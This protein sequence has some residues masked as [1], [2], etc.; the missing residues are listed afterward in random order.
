[1]TQFR[2]LVLDNSYMLAGMYPLDSNEIKGCIIH[3]E[4]AMRKVYTDTAIPLI[5]YNVRIKTANDNNE[6]YWPSVIVLNGYA[7]KRS[8]R[9]VMTKSS[10]YIRDRGK[11]QYCAEPVHKHEMTLDHILP[12]S[13]GGK[14]SW[15]NVCLA[16]RSCNSRKSDAMPRGEWANGRIY[17]KPTHEA[18]IAARRDFPIKVFDPN[19]IDFLGNWNGDIAIDNKYVA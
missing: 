11:C 7:Q 4:D 17:N 2:T 9:V 13:K 3:A 12:T 1:M 5:N 14:H 6:Y 18:L 15:D 16:C 8:R 10:I 19:W